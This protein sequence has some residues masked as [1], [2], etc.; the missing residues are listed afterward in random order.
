MPAQLNLV[1]CK[2]THMQRNVKR[3]IPIYYAVIR[4]PQNSSHILSSAIYT[5]CHSHSLPSIT[6]N[7]FELVSRTMIF[8]GLCTMFGGRMLHVTILPVVKIAALK[9]WTILGPSLKYA[10]NENWQKRVWLWEEETQTCTSWWFLS[11]ILLAGCM[12]SRLSAFDLF[13]NYH[14]SAFQVAVDITNL[15]H[16][17]WLFVCN[18]DATFCINAGS[19]LKA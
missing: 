12:S 1:P 18:L 13:P 11:T 7:D 8:P 16:S 17:I 15:I 3:L 10:E 14:L 9:S 6:L 19:M 5:I 2:T 4:W